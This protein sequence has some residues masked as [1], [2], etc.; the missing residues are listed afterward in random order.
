MAQLN[1]VETELTDALSSLRGGR[2]HGG[3]ALAAKMEQ[4]LS[5]IALW[6]NDPAGFSSYLATLGA[7]FMPKTKRGDLTA[8]TS[9]ELGLDG[10]AVENFCNGNLR[11]HNRLFHYLRR[12]NEGRACENRVGFRRPRSLADSMNASDLYTERT[13]KVLELAAKFSTPAEIYAYVRDQI[14]FI[15]RFGATQSATQVI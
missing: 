10:N 14:R 9:P 13:T 1:Q 6:R 4:S 7:H 5:A 3:G 8:L 15:H 11:F 12:R 2:V